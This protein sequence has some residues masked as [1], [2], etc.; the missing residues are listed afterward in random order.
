ME[1]EE[2]TETLVKAFEAAIYKARAEIV[3]ES[4]LNG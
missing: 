1:T 4:W 2:V 3:K